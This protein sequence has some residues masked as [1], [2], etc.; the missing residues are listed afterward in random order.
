[1]KSITIHGLD[2]PL[3]SMLKTRAKE[4]GKSLN[5]TIKGLLEQAFGIRRVPSQPHRAEF[6][7]FLGVWSNDELKEFNKAVADNDIILSDDWK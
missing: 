1:M 6:E 4:D 2:N 3:W 7:E 5:Q